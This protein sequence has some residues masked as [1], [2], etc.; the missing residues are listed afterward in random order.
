[1]V[2]TYTFDCL[3]F[4]FF[5]FFLPIHLVRKMAN[6][7]RLLNR[8]RTKVLLVGVLLLALYLF[9]LDPSKEIDVP[10][11]LIDVD[12]LQQ[13][14]E[15]GTPVKLVS[16]KSP[17]DEK[18][19]IRDADKPDKAPSPE[20][21]LKAPETSPKHREAWLW[22]DQAIGVT[23]LFP[24]APEIDNVLTSLATAK[25]VNVDVLYMGDY[26]SGTSEKWVATLEGGQRA[27]MKLLWYVHASTLV[28]V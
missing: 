7:F 16:Y 4:H 23:E 17:L 3:S 9:I 10:D 26:E 13:E 20:A 12:S 5:V 27:M 15:I 25:I 8:V 11:H 24:D 2:F 21:D 22:A 19:F 6:L 28:N 1:M 18:L 14:V